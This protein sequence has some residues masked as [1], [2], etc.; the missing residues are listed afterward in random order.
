MAGLKIRQFGNNYANSI[1]KTDIGYTFMNNIDEQ[2]G[3]AWLDTSIH[4]LNSDEKLNLAELIKGKPAVFVNTASH[5][6]FT[7]QFAGLESLYQ[8]FK[9]KDLVVVG[10]PSNSFKQESKEAN[11][12]SAVCY[13]NFGVS[14]TM[15]ESVDVKGEN[16]NPIFKHLK[17]EKGAPRWNFY[18]Y[19]IGRDGQVVKKFSSFTN[20]SKKRFLRAVEQLIESE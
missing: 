12:T 20:P 9:E 1:K 11:N 15:T 13:Q 2:T 16:A 3:Y 17:Q 6:G 18:K 5:C 14:F 4:R 10:F 8:Q 7:P 19:L